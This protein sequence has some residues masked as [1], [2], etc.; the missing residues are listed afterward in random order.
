MTLY[1]IVVNIVH[2]FCAFNFRTSNAVQKYFNI[3]IFK[4]YGTFFPVLIIVTWH[5]SAQIL[6]VYERGRDTDTH[7]PPRHFV[8]EKNHAYR[9]YLYSQMVLIH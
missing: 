7:P 3:E 2:V 1:R 8:E 5:N 4:I 9:K 6:Y